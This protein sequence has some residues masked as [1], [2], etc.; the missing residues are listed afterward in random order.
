LILL[1]AR[2]ELLVASEGIPLLFALTV[3]TAAAAWFVGFEYAALPFGLL[4]L[5]L[6]VFRDPVRVIPAAPLGVV[7]PVDGTIMEVTTGD[8]GP[9]EGEA[10]CIRIHVSV[11]GAYT[12]RSPVEGKVME[13]HRLAPKGAHIVH[14]GGLWLR[15]DEGANVVLQFRG[16]RFGLVPRAFLQYGERVG[17]G[18]RCAWLRLTRI[19][20]I[21][22][23]AGG[24]VLVET[25]QRVMA[26]SAVLA[27]LPHSQ[28]G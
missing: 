23:P 11:F 22:L 15:T 7:S 12:A 26:G 16:K 10:H 17:Q 20:E 3:V 1:K 28:G 21:W 27:R 8:D 18:E 9:L 25:G 6:F 5:L 24:R 13:L 2:R 19:A 14:A 4:V